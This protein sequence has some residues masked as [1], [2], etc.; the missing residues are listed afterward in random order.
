MKVSRIRERLRNMRRTFK[1]NWLLFKESKIGVFG[2]GII[3]FFLVIALLAPI[4]DIRDPILFRAP[5]EDVID[6]DK[7]WE[8]D[9]RIAYGDVSGN[10]STA[11]R[12]SGLRTPDVDRVYVGASNKLV[13]LDPLRDG[14]YTWPSP[15]TTIGNISTSV[16]VVNYGENHGVA[17]E[18]Y[19]IYFGTDTGQFYTVNDYDLSYSIE[20]QTLDAPIK[21]IAVYNNEKNKDRDFNI[22]IDIE[23]DD[24]P[25]SYNVSAPNIIRL[26]ENSYRMYY[27]DNNY[28]IGTG[29]H[30]YRISSAN[31]SD[32]L[33]WDMETN[34]VRLEPEN[35]TAMY[36][37]SYGAFEPEVIMF[38]NGNYRMFYVGNNSTS[39]QILSAFSFDG[40]N[41]I[42][43]GLNINAS[44]TN[45]NVTSPSVIKIDDNNCTMYYAA[46]NG[47]A[48]R[49]LRADSAN[50]GVNWG[51]ISVQLK[52]NITYDSSGLFSPEVILLS[53]GTYRMYYTGFDGTTHRIL[54]AFSFNGFNWSRESGVRMEPLY[55]HQTL[56][57]DSPE[58]IYLAEDTY[59]LYYTGTEQDSGNDW[60]TSRILSALSYDGLDYYREVKDT[61]YVGTEKGTL[62]EF[63]ANSVELRSISLDSEVHMTSYPLQGA[64]PVYSPC[65]TQDGERLVVGTSNSTL[66]SIT[67][68][69]L[70]VNWSW[71]YDTTLGWSSTPI[72]NVEGVDEVVYLGTDDG[73]LYAFYVNNGTE[74]RSWAGLT[75]VDPKGGPTE[76]IGIQIFYRGQ[77]DGGVLTTPAVAWGTD[78]TFI[79]VGSSTGNFYKIGREER[80]S[81]EEL[82]YRPPGYIDAEFREPEGLKEDFRFEVQPI[83]FHASGLIF[84][85]ENHDNVTAQPDDD[86]GIV[87]ALSLNLSVSWKISESNNIKYS[88]VRSIP[89]AWPT[90]ERG[91]LWFV[92]SDGIAFSY[93]AAGEYLAPLPPTWIKPSKS[94]NIYWLGTDLIGH[95]VF[96]QVMFGARTALLV[97]FLAAFFAILIGLII[98]VVSG[99]FGSKI[100]AVLMRFT[101]V[102]I[103]IPFLPFVIVLAAVLGPSIWNIIIVIAIL[104]W[105]GTARVIRSEVLSLKERPF[106]ESARV[107]GA[108]NIRIMF[109]HIAPNVL[110]LA[111]LYMTFMV[112]GAILTEAALSF[113]GLGDF[114]QPSW[115]IMLFY[116]NQSNT[117][118]YWWLLWPPGLCIAFL[119]LGF[120]LVGRAF[121]Q[122]VNPRLRRR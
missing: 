90:G 2:L 43:E 111:F 91:N 68:W 109:K 79:Y 57:V 3:I 46:Y 47:T 95:D 28:D 42:K 25:F 81:S 112:S 41:W 121:E 72:L 1:D 80:P 67:T 59:R 48:W 65:L 105:G 20:S 4:L 120:Y 86:K 108:S 38:S 19:V 101:D 76:R 17:E 27:S 24:V 96:A 30:T 56:G 51:N 102:I 70:R 62:Y 63:D 5:E 32:G 106:I 103:V 33:N 87:Y 49:I 73:W 93:A 115:G 45:I 23:T 64:Y 84:V 118:S 119:S 116:I 26:S 69:D 122:I 16:V 88:T 71:T 36:Y 83:I 9:V 100:D 117:L 82:D 10:T 58:V 61:V 75:E 34:E 40:Y 29:N 39:L 11:V 107:T 104:G 22:R 74:V 89:F 55:A 54:S 77:P 66:Y 114:T 78:S 18:D 44:A 52:P 85:M 6:F 99:Y 12:L 53:N 31:S 110:P 92:T 97:G 14:R 50:G 113:I 7:D 94:G 35:K 98:G 21:S 37:D 8:N 13:A 60:V 15:I